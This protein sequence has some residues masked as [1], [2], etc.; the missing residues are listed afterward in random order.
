MDTCFVFFMHS[1]MKWLGNCLQEWLVTLVTSITTSMSK[2]SLMIHIGEI[3]DND[4]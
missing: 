4:C 2:G 1:E 3:L